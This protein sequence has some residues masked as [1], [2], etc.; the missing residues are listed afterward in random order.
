MPTKE[1][2]ARCTQCDIIFKGNLT[3]EYDK[4]QDPVIDYT[5]ALVQ[6]I[7]EHHWKFRTG[8]DHGSVVLFVNEID[9]NQ[10]PLEVPKENTQELDLFPSAIGTLIVARTSSPTV[11]NTISYFRRNALDTK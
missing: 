10:E 2:V 5:S 9:A 4:Y 1:L 8:N 11:Y 6:K 3:W 7:G